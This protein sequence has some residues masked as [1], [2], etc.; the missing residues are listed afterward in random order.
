MGLSD[1]SIFLVAYTQGGKW[2][3]EVF[4]RGDKIQHLTL[5]LPL[6]PPEFS[7]SLPMVLSPTLAYLL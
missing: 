4:E 3:R 5:S 2:G 7:L 6:L 1:I